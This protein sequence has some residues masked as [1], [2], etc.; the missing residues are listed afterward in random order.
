M[1]KE[2]VYRIITSIMLLIFLYYMYINNF[3]LLIGLILFTFI[4]WIEFNF[5]ILKIIKLK[6]K[7][8]YFSKFIVQIS[9]FIYLILFSY[10]FW[11][12]LNSEN[13][14]FFLFLIGVCIV[15]DI[16]GLICGKILKGKKLTKISPNKTISGM[17][18]SFIFSI[19]FMEIYSSYNNLNFLFY[20]LLIITITTSAVSQLGDLF[21]SY[22]KRK[23][24]VKNTSELLPG[25]G[26]FLDR[27]DGILFGLPFGIFISYCLIN[28]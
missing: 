14:I 26:G 16:S 24:K 5:L 19:I 13:K 18:G 17:I 28:I 21:I 15:T 1:K 27:F 11:N 20:E 8:N 3:I 2:L 23:A 6:K 10:I 12:Y 4:V 25:H 7:L 22:I 9:A